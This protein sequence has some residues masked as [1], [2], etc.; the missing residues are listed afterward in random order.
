[1]SCML[2]KKQ[3]SSTCWEVKTTQHSRNVN[4]PLSK[5]LSCCSS[6]NPLRST[7]SYSRLWA[8]GIFDML[9]HFRWNKMKQ[10]MK[11]SFLQIEQTILFSALL[12]LK[13]SFYYFFKLQAR[14]E[15]RRS[16]EGKWGDMHW[17]SQTRTTNSSRWDAASN[18]P[19]LRFKHITEQ[20]SNSRLR[21]ERVEA[22]G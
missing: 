5:I 16:R 1:M 11:S 7:Q 8:R 20:T 22:G 19:G 13:L 15:T 12:P 3:P 9:F 2:R 6:K 17:E 21:E 4:F 10:Y 14:D 18:D